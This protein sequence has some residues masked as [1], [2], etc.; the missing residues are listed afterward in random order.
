MLI[1]I[2]GPFCD[3]T[4]EKRS[5]VHTIT[6]FFASNLPQHSVP[7]SYFV[8]VVCVLLAMPYLRHCPLHY[9]PLPYFV[10]V[11][12]V[13][14]AMPYLRHCPLHYVPLP[15]CVPVV[16]VLSMPCIRHWPEGVCVAISF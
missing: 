1:V 3:C 13:L 12:C 4:D 5:I 10:P 7:Q 16:C 2:N 14:L 15:Y 9:V 8:P 6:S 11:V